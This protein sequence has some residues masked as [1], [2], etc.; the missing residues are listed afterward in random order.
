MLENH[1]YFLSFF[2]SSDLDNLLILS[3]SII[4]S[5]E[6]GDSK[7]L[8]ILISVLLPA[9]EKPQRQKLS[10]IQYLNQRDQLQ[11]HLCS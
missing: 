10:L 6:V 7:L 2:R 4:T 8:N 3:P 1:T 9:P 11:E 5:P